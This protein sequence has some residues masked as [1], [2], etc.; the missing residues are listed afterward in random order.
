MTTFRTPMRFS[1]L[2]EKIYFCPHIAES[3]NIAEFLQKKTIRDIL[4]PLYNGF[5]NKNRKIYLRN[6]MN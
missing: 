1:F 2:N 4:A 3:A 6:D 5:T